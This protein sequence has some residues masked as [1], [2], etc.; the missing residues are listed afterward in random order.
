MEQDV[1]RRRWK[2]RHT[3]FFLSGLFI[4]YSFDI[5][6]TP[7]SMKSEYPCNKKKVLDGQLVWQN[8]NCQTCHQLFGLGGYLGPDLTNVISEPGKGENVVKAMVN[9]GSGQMP[10]FSMEEGEMDNL[11]EFLKS[12]DATG[13]ADPK[14]FKKNSLGMIENNE[15]K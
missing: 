5:Y 14:S 3:F 4:M 10:A 12:V 11:I 6:I 9:S 8:H 2:A 15:D 13:T 7:L 1:K